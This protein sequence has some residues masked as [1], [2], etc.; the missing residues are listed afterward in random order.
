MKV[1]KKV[2]KIG[3]SKAIIINSDVSVG[4]GKEINIGDK[5]EVDILRVI[6][7]EKADIPQNNE[8]RSKT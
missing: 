1:I 5:V 3:K 2:I 8:R 7:D 6:K 4:N